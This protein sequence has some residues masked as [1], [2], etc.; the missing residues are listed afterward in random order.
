[1]FA[2]G[3]VALGVATVLYARGRHDEH[4][5]VAPIVAPDQAGVAIIGGF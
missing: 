1:M 4:T 2:T 5:A 3:C